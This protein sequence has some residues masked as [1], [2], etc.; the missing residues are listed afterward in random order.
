MLTAD[1][2]KL[3]ISVG[4]EVLIVAVVLALAAALSSMSPAG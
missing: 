3:R 2:R 1:L 4:V